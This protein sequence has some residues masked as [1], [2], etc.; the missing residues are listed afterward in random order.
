MQ[1]RHRVSKYQLI[2]G[3]SN[4]IQT[5]SIGSQTSRFLHT[6]YEFGGLCYTSVRPTCLPCRSH[7]ATLLNRRTDG[8]AASLARSLAI[9]W[10]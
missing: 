10:N 5:D 6:L 9:R 3:D 8:R 1:K 2:S 4:T 7:G